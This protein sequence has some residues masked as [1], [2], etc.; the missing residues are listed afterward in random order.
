[1]KGLGLDRR[2]VD[3][4]DNDSLDHWRLAEAIHQNRNLEPVSHCNLLENQLNFTLL[5]LARDELATLW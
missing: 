2:L 4:V 3:T 1:M 5:Y